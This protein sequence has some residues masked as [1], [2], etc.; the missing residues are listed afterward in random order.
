MRLWYPLVLSL[1]LASNAVAQTAAPQAAAAA[2]PAGL[3]EDAAPAVVQRAVV[4][5]CRPG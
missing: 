3:K 4:E 1:A 5:G 2:A